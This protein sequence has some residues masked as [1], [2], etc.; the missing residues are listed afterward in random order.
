MIAQLEEPNVAAV[1]WNQEMAATERITSEWLPPADA[2]AR[3]WAKTHIELKRLLLL[4]DDWD[5]EGAK[6]TSADIID[7]AHALLKS[8]YSPHDAPA[9]VVANGDGGIHIEWQSGNQVLLVEISSP[10]K[11]LWIKSAPGVPGLSWETTWA[12]ARATLTQPQARVR[13]ETCSSV[14]MEELSYSMV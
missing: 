2:A 8:L 5:G 12:P 10:Y 7:S 14:I 1:V 9:R 13:S 11:G 4:R 3:K 6:A